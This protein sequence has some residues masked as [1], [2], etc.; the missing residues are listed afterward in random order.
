MTLKFQNVFMSP[1]KYPC[2]PFAFTP[3]S[4]PP[5]SLWQPV[6]HFLSLWICLFWSVHINE[7]I[8]YVAFLLSTIFSRFIYFLAL[9]LTSQT[10]VLY[11]DRLHFVCLVVS[12]LGL[13]W[14]MLLGTVI[15]KCLYE[16]MFSVFLAMYLG[17]EC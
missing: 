8:Y 1:K 14:I 6:I 2:Y 11:M 17:V 3:H 9:C 5:L 4:P 7:I 10:V 16:Y 15:H 13:L 12:T